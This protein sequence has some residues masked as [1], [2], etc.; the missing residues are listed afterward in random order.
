MGFSIA[1]AIACFVTFALGF[2]DGNSAAQSRHFRSIFRERF[3]FIPPSF[4]YLRHG[5]T[6]P[7]RG[8]AARVIFF[9]IGLGT[10]L[11]CAAFAPGTY[12]SALLTVALQSAASAGLG[13]GI[14]A[15][16]F[17]ASKKRALFAVAINGYEE[18]I[19]ELNTEPRTFFE[20]LAVRG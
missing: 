17:H 14:G 9:F 10:V 20:V 3:N 7:E 19:A 1:V 2:I 11:I 4:V 6:P 18:A 15:G 8:K 13:F 12:G 5:L 16:A